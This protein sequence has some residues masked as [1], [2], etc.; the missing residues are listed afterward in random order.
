[1]NNTSDRIIIVDDEIQ[2]LNGLRRTLS[3]RFIIN[4]FSS[5]LEALDFLG[6]SFDI[7]VILSDYSMP[8]MNGIEFFT[9]VKEIAPDAIRILITGNADLRVAI[10]SINQG[11]IYKFLTKPVSSDLLI[12]TIE[13]AVEI[14]TLKKREMMLQNELKE[15]YN[16]IEKDLKAAAQL[17]SKFLPKKAVRLF[18]LQIAADQIPSVYVSGDALNYFELDDHVVGFFILDVSGHGVKSALFSFSLHNFLNPLPRK[19]SPLIKLLDDGSLAPR[20]PERVVYNLN[21]RFTA[22]IDSD[23][24]TI[25][26]GIIDCRTNNLKLCCAGHPYPLHLSEGKVSKIGK[27][28]FPVSMFHSVSYD[29]FE[30]DFKKGDKLMLYSDGLTETIGKGKTNVGES[31]L[32]E[33][34]EKKSAESAASLSAEIKKIALD[35]KESSFDDDMTFMIIGFD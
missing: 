19:R 13:S 24:F 4:S 23:Y 26:Y 17:Q 2:V 31:M 10:E 16:R 34:L 1:M 35:L 27:A 3:G 28:N 32:I 7:S 29:F 21:K 6:N 33:L 22:E 30:T 8:I 18:N 25:V 9:K 15:A 5:P 14:F 11:N 12:N 20:S